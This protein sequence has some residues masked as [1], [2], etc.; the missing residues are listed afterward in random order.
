MVAVGRAPL[1]RT[2]P[3]SSSLPHKTTDPMPILFRLAATAARVPSVRQNVEGD[4]WLQ[5]R[6]RSPV[7]HCF[8]Q[9]PIAP[10]KPVLA[11]KAS[12]RARVFDTRPVECTTCLHN[13]T[14]IP[15][16]LIDL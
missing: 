3:T 11:V 6:R 7:G 16:R 10:S 4:V 9:P 2:A 15:F 5:H 13:S 8:A 1:P 14:P 12:H